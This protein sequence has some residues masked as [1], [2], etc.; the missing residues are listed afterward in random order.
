ML[1]RVPSMNN[2]KFAHEEDGALLVFFAIC[3]AAIFLV[4]SLSFDLGQ[5]ASTQT[6][7]QSFA[8]NAALAAA[9]ELNG[10]PGAI[11]RAERAAR[12]LISDNFVF[13]EEADGNGD[14][15]KTLKGE[16]DYDI[17][18]YATL[19]ADDSTPMTASS[20]LEKIAANDAV[21]R[22]AR[23]VVKPVNVDW[24]FANLL[25][26]F[27]STALPS[28]AVDAEAVAG[29]TS[30]SCDVAPVFFCLPDDQPGWTPSTAIGDSILLKA[31]GQSGGQ[32]GPAWTPGNFTWLNVIAQAEAAWT[33][34]GVTNPTGPCAEFAKNLNGK[35]N[36]DLYECLFSAGT[37]T[38]CFENGQLDTKPGGTE[39]VITAV[40]NTRFDVF[41]KGS[42]SNQN[43]SLFAPAPVVTTGLEASSTCGS[44]TSNTS[45]TM[46]LP[47]DDCF[48]GHGGGSCLSYDGD[49]RFGDGDWSAGRLFYADVNYSFDATSV[50]TPFSYTAGVVDNL[51]D[52]FEN[53][54]DN[55]DNLAIIQDELVNIV[56]SSGTTQVYHRYDPFRPE[57]TFP[58]PSVYA[59]YP[60]IENG[61]SQ[62]EYY[63]AEV[64]VS[65]YTDPLNVVSYNDVSGDYEFNYDAGTL[66]TGNPNELIQDIDLTIDG[67]DYDYN[68]LGASVANCNPYYDTNPRRRTL[69]AAILNCSDTGPNGGINGFTKDMTAE[70]FAEI[71]L[72]TSSG[73]MRNT[74]TGATPNN[75]N[76]DKEIYVQIIGPALNSGQYTLD[77]GRFRNLVQLYR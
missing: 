70:Y 35:F 11:E 59:G 57:G 39:G 26:L 37:G 54:D 7:L 15:D 76:A 16:S 2:S 12:E 10:F 50:G 30:L 56:D 8:D 33:T 1:N 5:R 27:S 62:W 61:A 42:G 25:T 55:L 45:T 13:G 72:L 65:L 51:A 38:L 64:T 77:P 21:A 69:V 46:G 22:Y 29:Y 34:D 58:K 18:F 31:G 60:V 48:T 52:V 53:T 74:A 32:N 3:A 40:F 71:F 4:A 14:A 9:G 17:Y 43:D 68:R 28:E 63:Q 23:V 49:V 44:S 75:A 36:P 47:A 20:A 24:D 41:G 6:E 66:V 73:T 19:P 67:T